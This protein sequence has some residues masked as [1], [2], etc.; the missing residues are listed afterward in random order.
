MEKKL[1]KIWQ[2]CVLVIYYYCIY[3]L[4]AKN[5]KKLVK[6]IVHKPESERSRKE[7]II[8]NITFFGVVIYAAVLTVF[9]LNAKAQQVE[10]EAELLSAQISA[11]QVAFAR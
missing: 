5:M 1:I 6:K 4:Y 3:F 11:Q 10:A 2:K 7:K 8:R 9:V